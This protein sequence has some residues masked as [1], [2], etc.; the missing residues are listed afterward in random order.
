MVSG[1]IN[2]AVSIQQP[3]HKYHIGVGVCGLAPGSNRHL[4]LP[5]GV[6]VGICGR[7]SR[8]TTLGRIGIV[9]HLSMGFIPGSV[10][11]DHIYGLFLAVDPARLLCA[12]FAVHGNI[13]VES[14]ELAFTVLLPY[15]ALGIYR[16]SRILHQ[17]A[18]IKV[19]GFKGFCGRTVLVVLHDIVGYLLPL[20]NED[21]GVVLT[22]AGGHHGIPILRLQHKAVGIQP[23]GKFVPFPIQQRM[24][25]IGRSAKLIF[26]YFFAVH[27][28]FILNRIVCTVS[29][30]VV[31]K[32][33]LN[34]HMQP[35]IVEN[36]GS[37]NIAKGI[38]TRVLIVKLPICRAKQCA[39]RCSANTCRAG[40]QACIV[41]GI[42]IC[43][44]I[45]TLAAP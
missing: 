25:C 10:N 23:A 7:G 16:H 33:K 42:L 29:V 40:V 32:V 36:V 8:N 45:Y 30:P 37:I 35:V 13:P 18:V 41:L 12:V 19:V 39:Y 5:D 24:F 21:H 6:L 1:V 14:L 15:P 38:N 43:S 27:D 9:N 44:G 34:I 31:C 11:T 20:G 28:I 4:R 3:S 26:I 22:V 2:N 17:L